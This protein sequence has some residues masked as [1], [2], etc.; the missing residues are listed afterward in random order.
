MSNVRPITLLEVVRKIFTKFI[1]M[2]LSDI[3]QKR[4]ILCKANYCELKDKDAKENSKELWIVLQDIT[5]A[6]DSI[7]LNF[8]QLT[9]KRIGLPPHAVQC[10]INIFK[11]RKVQIA[12]AFELSPIFQ[13]EDGID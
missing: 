7:S 13:A 10:I 2:Q 6:F 3:L 11:G 9:L 4:D 5:K 1:S 8:L 12:T